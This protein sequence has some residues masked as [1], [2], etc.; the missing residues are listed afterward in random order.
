MQFNKESLKSG[1]S[2]P[3]SSEVTVGPNDYVDLG[4]LVGKSSELKPNPAQIEYFRV[5]EIQARSVRLEATGL[6]TKAGDPKSVVMLVPL[7]KDKPVTLFSL[8][9]EFKV[10]AKLLSVR[11]GGK[12]NGKDFINN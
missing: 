2:K 12:F 9:G 4:S 3:I 6:A 5:R 7:E 11:Y 8:R 1:G 10:T